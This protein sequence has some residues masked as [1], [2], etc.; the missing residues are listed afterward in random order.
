MSFRSTRNLVALALA[1]TLAVL[2]AAPASAGHGLPYHA[3]VTLDGSQEVP[4]VDTD[5][6]GNCAVILEPEVNT[7]S[8]SCAF[9]TAPMAAHIHA[10]SQGVNGPVAIALDAGRIIQQSFTLTEEQVSLAIIGDLYI[11]FHTADV[12]SGEIRGQIVFDQVPNTW[13]MTADG[14]GDDEV[15]PVDVENTIACRAFAAEGDP[16]M[17][18]ISVDCVH[19][20]SDAS[21]AHLHMGPV[22]DNGPVVE[23]FDTAT[24]PLSKRFTVDDATL[25]AFREGNTYINVHNDTFPGGVVR[26]QFDNAVDGDESS[27]LQD[28]RFEVSVSGSSP[29]GPF[30]GQARKVSDTSTTFSFF[31]RDNAELLVKVL[32]FCSVGS[33]AYGVFYSAG[34]DVAFDLV[35]RDTLTGTEMTYSNAQG[36]QAAPISDFGTFTDC[37]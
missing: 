16:D 35:V 1:T 18:L 6:Y 7:L 9:T 33:G 11:N 26:A 34:T 37:P 21:A 20:V 31:S 27:A 23:G 12:P 25:Q 36:N 17:N 28:G 4:P 29:F 15:P 24:S 5:L 8:L 30:T 13:S 14:S 32:D 10:G 19:D 2:L 3:F 22:D